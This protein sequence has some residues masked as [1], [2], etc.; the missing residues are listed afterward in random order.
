MNVMLSELLNKYRFKASP[1]PQSTD[2]VNGLKSLARND[3]ERALIV[4]LMEK[5][6][7]YDLSA[8]TAKSSKLANGTFATDITIKAS[9]Y[10]ADGEG[11]EEETDLKDNIEIGAF[12][13]RPDFGEFSRNDV[14]S[15]KRYPIISGEK[16]LRIITKK[17]PTFVGIDPYNKYIDRNGDD[18]IIAVE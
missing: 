12:L 2:L 10:Y 13:Q 11:N 17:K 7:I 4:D 16:K 15:L 14:I 8:S 9:K 3:E 5:I 1:Y 18:N 6:T